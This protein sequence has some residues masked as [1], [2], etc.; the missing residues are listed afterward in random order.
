MHMR[1]VDMLKPI[2]KDINPQYYLAY[3]KQVCYEIAETYSEIY[4]HLIAKQE[5]GVKKPSPKKLLEE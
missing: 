1:R 5:S 2:L 3:L 4:D